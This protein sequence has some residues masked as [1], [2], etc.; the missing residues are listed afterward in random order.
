MIVLRAS[1]EGTSRASPCAIWCDRCDLTKLAENR[2]ISRG[3]DRPGL[4]EVAGRLSN[5]RQSDYS[6]RHQAPRTLAPTRAAHRT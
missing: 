3:R 1:L 6:F 4:R 2:E 5:F